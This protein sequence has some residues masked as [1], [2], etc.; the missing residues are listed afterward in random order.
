MTGALVVADAFIVV[1]H[2]EFLVFA[3]RSE[4]FALFSDSQRV[5]LA[6]VGA[7]KHADGLAVEAVPIG[8]FAV[9]AGGQQLGLVGMVDH[10]LEH[11]RFE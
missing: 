11:G 7:V 4:M 1:P 3:P 10:L 6:G 5:D 2:L 9:G 8:D